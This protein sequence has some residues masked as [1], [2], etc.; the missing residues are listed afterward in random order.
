MLSIKLNLRMKRLTQ[1]R[2]L[3]WT[4]NILWKSLKASWKHYW[5]NQSAFNWRFFKILVKPLLKGSLHSYRLIKGGFDLKTFI[6]FGKY[7]VRVV[8]TTKRSFTCS[9]WRVL[10]TRSHVN[11][12][13]NN[14]VV[15]HL[16]M[17][18]STSTFWPTTTSY[19]SLNI[20]MTNMR[21]IMQYVWSYINLKFAFHS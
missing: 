4:S 13:V 21:T 7:W 5:L 14:H 11:D 10:T 1:T 18:T 16:L 3:L 9:L 20:P 17:W 6:N 2:K 12:H 15:V 8:W 19:N